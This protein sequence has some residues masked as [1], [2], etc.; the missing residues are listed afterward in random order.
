VRIYSLVN[1]RHHW[2]I[3]AWDT[4]Q[5]SQLLDPRLL[6]EAAAA[7]AERGVPDPDVGADHWLQEAALTATKP[8]PSHAGP[9]GVL[10][11]WSFF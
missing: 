4:D 11:D 8:L 10:E 1:G 7:F 9:T 3:R 6:P 2:L 5:L